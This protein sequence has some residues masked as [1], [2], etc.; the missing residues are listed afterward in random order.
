METNREIALSNRE[1]GLLTLGFAVFLFCGMLLCLEVGRRLFGR[2]AR[3]YGITAPKGVGIVDSAVYGLLALLLGFSFSGAASRF[4]KRRDLVI[5]EVDEIS[6]A[7]QYIDMLPPP[8]QAAIRA[9]FRSYLDA[10]IAA[11]SVP[12][13][14]AEE[15]RQRQKLENAREGIWSNAVAACLAE[16]GEK[17]RMLLLPKL[18][19]MF[20]TVNIEFLQQRIHPPLIIFVL[21]AITAFAAAIFAG[22]SMASERRNWIYI[23]G[24]AAT[25]SIATYVILELESPRVG[26]VRVDAIDRA[27]IELRATMK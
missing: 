9:G 13:A 22:Y 11:Y 18:N 3:K 1:F 8:P 15:K 2:Q 25:I 10:L 19:D 27:L 17:A 21:L 6:T 7:W 24:V 14:S 4:D 26:W 12:A 23:I 5:Q 20:D 16:G